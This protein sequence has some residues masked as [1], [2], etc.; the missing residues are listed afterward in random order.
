[1]G[2]FYK[3]S[4]QESTIDLFEKS[5]IYKGDMLEYSQTYS[6]VVD[7]NFGEK[8]LF[9]RVNR[10]Y[11]SIQPNEILTTFLLT[12]A[13][14]SVICQAGQPCPAKVSEFQFSSRLTR[15]WASRRPLQSRR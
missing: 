4:N 3:E 13:I 8:Y 6:N 12:C 2:I 14:V 5:I 15:P 11:I 10:N 7:F 9:G 1:M